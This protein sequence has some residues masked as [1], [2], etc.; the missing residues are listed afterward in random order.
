LLTYNPRLAKVHWPV[1]PLLVTALLG[2]CL[3]LAFPLLQIKVQNF[4]YFQF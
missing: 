3:G 1:R 4:I 2:L